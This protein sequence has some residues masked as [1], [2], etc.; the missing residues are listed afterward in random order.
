MQDGTIFNTSFMIGKWAIGEIVVRETMVM[1]EMLSTL[2]LKHSRVVV[3]SADLQVQLYE[4][5]V[6]FKCSRITNTRMLDTFAR[7]HVA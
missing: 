6:S 4:Q 1:S 5:D 7:M 2:R 3:Q